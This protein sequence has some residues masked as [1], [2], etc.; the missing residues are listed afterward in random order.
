MVMR[1]A[2]ARDIAAIEA[3]SEFTPTEIRQRLH[4]IRV[5]IVNREVVCLWFGFHSGRVAKFIV[6][7]KWRRQGIG[8]VMLLDVLETVVSAGCSQYIRF[9]ITESNLDA[10]LFMK[11]NGFTGSYVRNAFRT[12]DGIQFERELCVPVCGS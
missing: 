6:A 9:M 10:Q 8:T 3:V 1:D 4:L 11:V 12:E 7:P 5:G 2:Q